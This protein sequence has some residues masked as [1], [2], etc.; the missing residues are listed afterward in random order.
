ML[1]ELDF[2]KLTLE[3]K[4]GLLL[5][6]GGPSTMTDDPEN[7]QDCLELIRRHALGAMWVKPAVG[8]R[9]KEQ[10]AAIREAADYPILIFTDAEN[11]MPP[12]LIGCHGAIGYTDSEE[13][14]YAFGR[15]T[16]LRARE[17]GYNIVCNPLLDMTTKNV[18]CGGTVRSLGGDKYKT[19]RLAAAIARGMH[20]VGI[21]TVG[22]HYLNVPIDV[23]THMAEGASNFTKEE[24]NDYYLYPYFQLIKQGLLDGIMTDHSKLM[25]IDDQYP[26]SLSKKSTDILRHQGYDGLYVTDALSMMGVVAKF[27]V[28]G[29]RSLSVAG[30]NDLALVWTPIKP[31]FESLK[32]GFE[33]GIITEQR[34]DE[35]V[36]RVLA[37]QHKA[38]EMSKTMPA[39]LCQT[40]IDNIAAINRKC[41]AAITD[42]ICLPSLDLAHR[43]LFILLTEGD[44]D[45]DKAHAFGEDTFSDEWYRPMELAE[46]IKM[47][48]P[49]AEIYAINQFPTAS[50]N[51]QALQRSISYDDVVFITFCKSEAYIGRETYTTRFLSLIEA[52]QVTERVS[53]VVHFGNPF[54]LE[55]LPHVPRI[56]NGSQAFD[57]TLNAIDILAGLYSADGKIPYDIKLK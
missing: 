27:G 42:D 3:Q 47:R 22:K 23:D 53:A 13:M 18:P 40:D 33:S 39:P 11:G 12:Y 48:F 38:M 8:S 24:L 44:V 41:I 2:S 29:S 31:S 36:N 49:N 54:L 46:H 34:L 35:A 5:I 14:A 17:D 30:G 25:V 51:Y 32:K 16:G 15:V 50:Q 1:H 21:L 28:D 7:L 56:L 52:M 43:H 10:I 6:G 37:A 55:E 9:Y 20:D 26:T 4:L 57:C 45:L 19:T